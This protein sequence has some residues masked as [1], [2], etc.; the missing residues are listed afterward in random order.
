MRS[1]QTHRLL[2]RRLRPLTLYGLLT[3]WLTWPVVRDPLAAIPVGTERFGTVSLFNLWTLWWNVDRVGHAFS[4]YFDAPIFHPARD[5]F[6]FSELLLPTSVFAPV[7]WLTGSRILAYNV[8]VWS[9]LVLNG[10][11][12][13]RL[14]RTVGVRRSV[15]V[16]GGGAMVLLP[17]V[18]WQLGVPQ[19]V[20]LWGVL[21]TWS[22]VWRLSR[23]PTWPRAVELGL[24]FGTT[25]HLCAHQGL[26]LAVL[27][28]SG[29]VLLPGRRLLSW[30]AVGRWAVA[31]VVAVAVV[32]PFAWKQ[33]SVFA[34]EKRFE[35]KAEWA[36]RLSLEAGDYTV[37]VFPQLV[38]PGDLSSSAP[39]RE[40]WHAN[41]G[42]L[43]VVLA[44]VGVG[45]GLRFRRRREWTAWLLL[46]AAAAFALSLGPRLE[47]WGVRPWDGLVAYVPG[48]GQVRNV[49]RFAFFVQAAVVLLAA[50]GLHGLL[51][52]RPPFARS[53]IVGTTC[54]LG[55]LAVFE[56]PP[57]PTG[58]YRP[59]AVTLHKDWLA[60]LRERSE[61]TDA[62]ACLP[63]AAGRRVGD[64][65]VT[66]DWMYLG[67][68]H[69][70]P[71]VNG[72][73]GFFPTE[74]NVMQR[75]VNAGWP[76][77]ES[78]RT[79]ADRDVRWCLVDRVATG[80]EPRSRRLGALELRLEFESRTSDVDLYRLV[81][82]RP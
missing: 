61:P 77:V 1:R 17:I 14:L 8:Y 25:Y 74:Y 28:V 42:W 38:E 23:E 80:L 58:T 11:F 29:A 10:V 78:L 59:P 50:V 45:F 16:G 34:Q 3:A 63:F 64:F 53:V 75:E 22:A 68:F 24:A 40:H 18:H 57:P 51:C 26:F 46:T 20:G 72:Y 66:N 62:V 15:A 2:F 5:T 81:D 47:V 82:H 55:V 4:G 54:V 65:E 52:W 79:M 12:A 36:W 9:S 71:L 6:V 67:T 33:R 70:R 35:R 56:M 32:G 30:R 37:G 43:K 31:A 69:G 39:R 44:C 19:Y 49:F 21:W 13:E 7:V 27:L 48:F 60:V 73:S 41:P 76:S